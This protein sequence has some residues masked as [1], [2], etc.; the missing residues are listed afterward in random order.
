M[1]AVGRSAL[2]RAGDDDAADVTHHQIGDLLDDTDNQAALLLQDMDA[3]RE[4]AET[5]EKVIADVV[6]R[7]ATSEARGE[8]LAKMCLIA[9]DRI[10][11]ATDIIEDDGNADEQDIEDERAFAAELRGLAGGK[12]APTAPPAPINVVSTVIFRDGKVLLARRGPGSFAGA[13]ETPGG[14]VKPG[15]PFP[16]AV[17]R[18][19]REELGVEATH[20]RRWL[21][22]PT[23]LLDPPLVSKSLRMT[24]FQ[25]DIG[26]QEP[27][28]LA[29]LE[30]R[31]CS[32]EEVLALPMTP[33]TDAVRSSLA[34]LCE[35]ARDGVPG[36]DGRC[37]NCLHP[38]Y[39]SKWELR[40]P[41]MSG[42]KHRLCERC[43]ADKSQTA[44]IIRDRVRSREVS[45]TLTPDA[46]RAL[47][48]EVAAPESHVVDCDAC[49][50]IGNDGAPGDPGK[51]CSTCQGYG[52]LCADCSAP[53]DG[54]PH[55][56]E[57]EVDYL[58]PSVPIA[59]VDAA[60][61]EAGGDPVEI[62]ARGAAFV[63]KLLEE[64][65]EHDVSKIPGVPG[66]NGQCAWCVTRSTKGNHR[67]VAF[68]GR[69]YDICDVCD[70]NEDVHGASVTA[71][72]LGRLTATVPATSSLDRAAGSSALQRAVLGPM[73]A[74][75]PPV[76]P[77]VVQPEALPPWPQ[78]GVKPEE[79]C[80]Y[81]GKPHQG[82]DSLSVD[83][84][85]SDG[86][87]IPLC[88]A[89]SHDNSFSCNA[90]RARV[91]ARKAA[92]A[93]A[94]ASIPTTEAALTQGGQ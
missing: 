83:S 85:D 69:F 23:F 53:S 18:E 32:R 71:R 22:E 44:D 6:K 19:L 66:L 7:L 62:G 15:E 35:P 40:Y 94:D 4:R 14:K 80:G 31:W 54:E 46:V 43:G 58:D 70:A 55:G 92:L 63:V 29:S 49:E 30:L 50:G 26:D 68:Q 76:E 79:A 56:C 87:R 75:V 65:A 88:Q 38:V 33:G 52:K 20:V 78:P 27:R 47:G 41:V 13:W 51:V 89:C 57:P 10:N 2:S 86:E 36:L 81:C 90:V 74:V 11:T 8:K 37:A 16:D 17:V 77:E 39:A 28:A 1:L 84:D 73:L 34:K 59:V 72:I 25:A 91:A 60:I 3:L 24:F 48:A 93:T 45:T 67:A 61:R 5:A 64:R 21:A 12:A 9:A 82:F 42:K